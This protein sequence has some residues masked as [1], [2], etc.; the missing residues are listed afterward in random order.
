MTVIEKHPAGGHNQKSHGDRGGEMTESPMGEKVRVVAK[1]PKAANF[2][3]GWNGFE[4]YTLKTNEMV[5]IKKMNKLDEVFKA[6][7]MTG[8][9]AS[10]YISRSY[11]RRP[12]GTHGYRLSVS[13]GTDFEFDTIEEAISFASNRGL[14]IA[15]SNPLDNFMGIEKHTPG[16]ESHNQKTHAT[17]GRKA[18]ARSPRLGTGKFPNDGPVGARGAT[19]ITGRRAG[20][21]VPKKGAVTPFKPKTRV[22]WKGNSITGDP[23]RAGM[24]IGVDR[25]ADKDYHPAARGKPIYK[26]KL[27]RPIRGTKK[28]V[29]VPHHE[30]SEV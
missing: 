20:S 1:V 28:I 29:L 9:T 3:V 19:K 26:V 11:D 23:D 21:F 14:P 24:V 10:A 2:E 5:A 18:G 4:F 25:I 15:K 27:D 17:G 22:V 30:L 6:G 8:A 13:G 12:D 7:G 16:G